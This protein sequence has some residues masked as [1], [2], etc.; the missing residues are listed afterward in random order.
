M[1]STGICRGVFSKFSVGSR[2]TLN[3]IRSTKC[4]QNLEGFPVD[5]V[6]HCQAAR[7]A[8]R[9]ETGI[10]CCIGI[11]ETKTKAKLANH[12][13][14]KRSEFLG[15]C[16][17]RDPSACQS[18]YPSLPV[19][20]VWGIGPAAA[21]KLAGMGVRSVD[22]L[23]ELDLKATRDALTVTGARVV[24]ESR[25]ISCLPLTLIAPQKKGTAV[26]RTFGRYITEWDE[27]AQAISA[28]ATR[29]GKS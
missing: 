4:S 15:V 10:P 25:G 28:F 24:M 11:A 23:V 6:E 27:L 18:L 5:L 20:E 19:S 2:P 21:E 7:I 16:D 22:Q 9:Q 8:I 26:T 1:S 13:A 3:L 12:I 29:A 14:K 17:L